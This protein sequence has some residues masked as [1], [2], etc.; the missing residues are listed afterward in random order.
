MK[1]KNL[2][3]FDF[4]TLRLMPQH[5]THLFSDAG[6]RGGPW[7][8]W[9]ITYLLPPVGRLI[10]PTYTSQPEGHITTGNPRIS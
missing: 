3:C 1:L 6:T 10:N 8:G 2:R 7:E 5:I 9:G 4:R